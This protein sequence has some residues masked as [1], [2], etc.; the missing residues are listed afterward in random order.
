MVPLVPLVEFGELEGAAEGFAEGL[1]PLTDPEDEAEGDGDRL[2]D[3]AVEGVVELVIVGVVEGEPETGEPETGVDAT[4][5]EGAEDGSVDGVEM[6]LGVVPGLATVGAKLL[7]PERAVVSRLMVL[8]L[9]V[10]V[11]QAEYTS[12]LPS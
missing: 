1:V 4:V 6:S 5:V 11:E 10:P 7:H 8:I 3:G 9:V 2:A 12:G